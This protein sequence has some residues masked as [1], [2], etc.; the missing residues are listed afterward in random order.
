MQRKELVLESSLPD[1]EI[2]TGNERRQTYEERIG[3]LNASG[4]MRGER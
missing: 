2:A 1:E 4:R 3:C